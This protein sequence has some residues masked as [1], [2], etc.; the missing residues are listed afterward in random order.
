MEKL[1]EENVSL[2]FTVQSLIK[3]RDNVKLEYQKLFNSI[4]KTRSQTQTEMDELIAHVSEKTYA[5]GAIRAENQNLFFTISELKTRLANVE[6]E[7]HVKSKPATLQTSPAKQRGANSN[8]NVI[9]HGMYKVVTTHESQTNE[10][11]HDLSSTRMTAASSVRRPMNRDS[12]VKN[13]VLANSK[14]PAKKVAIYVV[15]TGHMKEMYRTSRFILKFRECQERPHS[16]FPC[17]STCCSS[18]RR[19]QYMHRYGD[20]NTYIDKERQALLDFKAQLQDPNDRLSA[21]R[22]KE[23]STLT[24]LDSLDLHGNYFHGTIPKFI[25]SMTHLT[26]LNLGVNEFTETIPE[27]IGNMTQLI[28][29]DLCFNNF[30]GVIPQSIGSLTKLISLSLDHNSLYG[31]I[32]N[33]IG[34]LTNLTFLFLSE[35]SLYG[36]IPSELRNLTNLLTLSL[37]SLRDCTVENL[38]WLSSLSYLEELTL[39]GTSLAKANNWVNAVIVAMLQYLDAS[40][41]QFTGSLSHEIQHFSSLTAAFLSDESSAVL[42]NKVL[43]KVGDP[44]SFLI[45]CN[46]NKAFSCNTLADLGASIMPD[47]LYAILS[48]ETLKPTQ[49]SVRLAN[50]SFQY[51][52]GIAENMLVKVGKFTFPTD[53]VF[54]EMEED[55]KVPLILGKPFLHTADAVIRVK[56]KQLNLGVGTERMIFHIDSAMKHSYSNDDTCF[57]INVIDEILEEDFDA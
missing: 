30:N 43:P 15:E 7:N 32:P 36:K 40:S 52:V 26:N 33:A 5:Y 48:L 11:K 47:S 8:K 27:S 20:V 10:A 12:H 13:S 51:P 56:Q 16:H 1:E 49:M 57:S 18:R 4:K 55:S 6:K 38:D 37:D 41:S 54:L 46:F 24:Y 14:K 39:D 35:N 53:F 19:C 17:P 22:D 2:D 23:A 42:Q 45:P 34:S 9:A 50:R 29:L 31:T 25:F 21:W 3:E 28:Y 44:G